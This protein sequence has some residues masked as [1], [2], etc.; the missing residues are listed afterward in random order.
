MICC[1]SKKQWYCLKL[2]Y[3]IDPRREYCQNRKGYHYPFAI[4]LSTMPYT[5]T[6]TV[7][8]SLKNQTRNDHARKYPRYNFVKHI[9]GYDIAMIKQVSIANMIW[10][11]K[12]LIISSTLIWACN[13]EYQDTVNVKTRKLISWLF[14][15][16]INA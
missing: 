13:N 8:I 9:I 6:T 11:F 3:R 16:N 5:Q 12:T 15:I 14:C 10:N 7:F 2:W 1:L 4:D